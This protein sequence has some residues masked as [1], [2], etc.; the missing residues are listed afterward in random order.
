MNKHY[1]SSKDWIHFRGEILIF[2]M[3]TRLPMLT[4]QMKKTAVCE[5][6]EGLT[7]YIEQVHEEDPNNY[8]DEMTSLEQLRQDIRGVGKDQQGRD[9]LYKYFGQLELLERRIPIGDGE[10]QACIHFTW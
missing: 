4:I 3:A 5:W 7:K 8:A 6:K 1:K 2:K 9:L 10:K